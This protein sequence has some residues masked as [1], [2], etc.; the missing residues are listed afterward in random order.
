MGC[1]EGAKRGPSRRSQGWMQNGWQ[2][3]VQSREDLIPA[4]P[5]SQDLIA[6]MPSMNA[7]PMTLESVLGQRAPADTDKP[8][9][10]W[11]IE[12]GPDDVERFMQQKRPPSATGSSR[13]PAAASLR[14]LSAAGSCEPCEPANQ[15]GS[16]VWNRVPPE[17]AG[18]SRM[19]LL[20]QV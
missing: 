14:P 1:P 2:P 16:S 13:P 8:Q 3:G 7:G 10:R 11:L 20:H 9:N 4:V 12:D 5:S 15:W 17:L 18:P 6:S 19:R